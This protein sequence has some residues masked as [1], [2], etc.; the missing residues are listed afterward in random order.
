MIRGSFCMFFLKDTAVRSLYFG[1]LI[2]S[3][4][5]LNSAAFPLAVADH[6]PLSFAGGRPPS[7]AW[8]STPQGSGSYQVRLGATGVWHAFDPNKQSRRTVQTPVSTLF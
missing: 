2:R 5:L 7:T 6:S 1:K 4:T 8:K 3:E